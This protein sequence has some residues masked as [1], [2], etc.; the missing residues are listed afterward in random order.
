M[1][2]SRPYGQKPHH[3]HRAHGVRQAVDPAVDHPGQRFQLIQLFLRHACLITIFQHQIGDQADQI[4]ITATLT[5]SVDGALDLPRPGLNCNERIGNGNTAI[6]MTVNTDIGLRQSFTDSSNTSA[7]FFRHRAT[8]GITEDNPFC[9]AFMR[10]TG[11]VEGI[12]GIV[13][14]TIEE[15]FTI[16]HRLPPLVTGGS[17]GSLIMFRFSSSVMPSAVVTWKSHVL[18]TRQEASVSASGQHSARDRLMPTGHRGGSCQRRPNG[19]D[20]VRENSQKSVVGGI[21][22]GPAPSI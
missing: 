7:D 20:D 13:L 2:A 18:P 9:A 1:H 16:E 19:H 15:M 6:I 8:I 22:P 14:K 21:G 3:R 10:R 11:T 4:G 5:D 12:F 17:H